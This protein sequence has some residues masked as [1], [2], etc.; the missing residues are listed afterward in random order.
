[1]LVLWTADG[2]GTKNQEGAQMTKT[3]SL[4]RMQELGIN[5]YKP[6]SIESLRLAYDALIDISYWL[7][8][9][10]NPHHLIRQSE[11]AKA[12]GVT[13]QAV[14]NRV[15]RGLYKTVTIQNGD[16]MIVMEPKKK[17]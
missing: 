8:P 15:V 6:L 16:V 5:V 10:F 4:Q 13:R 17:K 9:K 7:D 2:M 12:D 14:R 1:M 11:I 3:E